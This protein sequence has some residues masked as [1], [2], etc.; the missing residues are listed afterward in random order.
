MSEISLT[1][2]A[3]FLRALDV[4]N[5]KEDFIKILVLDKDERPIRAIEGRVSNGSLSISGSSS[6]RRAGSLTF[7]AEETDND[8]TDVDNLL[9][10]NKK[11]KVLKGL[12]NTI[13]KVHDDIIWFNQGIYVITQPAITHGT[14]GVTISLQLK[15]K[16]ALLNGECGGGL[17]TSVTFHEYDQIIGY[18][19]NGNTETGWSSYPLMP[20]N[21]T[22]YKIKG[23]C[24]MWDSL[25][26]WHTSSKDMVGN[27]I[28]IP[29]KV[30][31]IIQTLVCN[32]GGEAISNIIIND[33]PLELKASVRYIGHDTLYFNTATS[34]YSLN[35]TDVAADAEPENWVAYHYNEDCGYVFTDFTYPG[36]LISAIGDNV[37]SVL[38]KIK[39]TLGNFEY[40]YDVDGHFVFQ[41]KK[42][43]L[44]TS[45]D[46]IQ[47]VDKTQ[48]L[49]S[50]GYLINS[51][52]YYVNFSNT[53]KSIYTFDEGSVLISAYSNTPK[54]SNIKNDFHIWGKN[55]NG[56][57]IHY[58]VAI[59]EKPQPPYATRS[60]VYETNEDGS[61]NGRIRLAESLDSD[62]HSYAPTDW[63]AELYMRGLEKKK[64][65]QRP[66]IYEQE[67]L[68]L[69]DIIYDMRQKE[70]K[71]DII[72]TPNN[73]KYWI[74]YIK[75]TELF[76]IA[77]ENVG[78]KMISHQNDKIKK[79]YNT[80]VPNVIM[81]NIN[82]SPISQA[83]II[84]KCEAIGQPKAQV[85]SNIFNN[86]AIG[87]VG[88]TS[89]E[90]LRDLMY[91]YTDY[92]ETISLTSIPIYY[93]DVNSR[94]TV[95]DKASGI[96]GDYI[97]NS[98]TIPLDIKGTMNISATR[99]LNR[100]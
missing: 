36:Q 81:V 26:G 13:D 25:K 70:F 100:D 40:F 49:N 65:E 3:D 2:D 61:Y 92:T 9:S 56:F 60:V 21:Y 58:H 22:V 54:Y 37:C 86:I 19:D 90:T 72:N 11:I 79:L 62:V 42:N 99:A 24:Y 39:T 43:Y 77:I 35:D 38:D 91:Q 50:L 73:L 89:Q 4:E 48:S 16:M 23:E 53:S 97:I 44:N 30:F 69:F 93:L 82:S 59:Q 46:P 78:I 84:A 31:D 66:D 98:I 5:L 80:D 88:Y 55:E 83:S 85:G 6:V 71:E 10:L 7:L 20:N 1:K 57:A 95:Y 34:V 51:D 8:L 87:T 76:D 64:N 75:P 15:D 29:Q 68:D 41:E 33:V 27:I 47:T 28:S 63:R 18:S 45:Y 52:N 14:N 94:I 74:D 96:N 17:P 67:L 32:Y 12:K